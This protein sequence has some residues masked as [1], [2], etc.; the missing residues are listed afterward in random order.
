MTLETAIRDAAAKGRVSL[1]VMPISDGKYQANLA[2]D[3]T[4]FRVHIAKDPIEAL[5]KVLTDGSAKPIEDAG[6][7]G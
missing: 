4:T 1:S 3:A 6:V 5:L 7:F 2:V